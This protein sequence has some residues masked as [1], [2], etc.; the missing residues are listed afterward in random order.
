[1]GLST[2]VGTTRCMRGESLALIEQATLPGPTDPTLE[3][4][5]A[6]Q[7]VVAPQ[8]L[9]ATELHDNLPESCL[10]TR[11][12]VMKLPLVLVPLCPET[13]SRADRTATATERCWYRITQIA[14]S[15]VLF[16]PS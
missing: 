8:V 4:L 9:L 1:M 12:E 6:R 16:T 2:H 14:G 10:V 15:S 7:L 11:T 5:V 3:Q 13:E